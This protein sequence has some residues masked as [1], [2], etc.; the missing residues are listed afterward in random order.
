[1]GDGG[2]CS[3]GFRIACN[4]NSEQTMGKYMPPVLFFCSS[5][6]VGVV[7]AIK[8][9]GGGF[10]WALPEGRGKRPLKP[11]PPGVIK[12]RAIS[13]EVRR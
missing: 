8:R 6:I 2:Q 4:R 10:C 9:K 11:K 5:M 13:P 12:Q 1:M 7:G 3:G